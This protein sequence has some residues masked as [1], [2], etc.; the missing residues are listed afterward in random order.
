MKELMEGIRTESS[1]IS[2]KL[3][4]HTNK[5]LESENLLIDIKKKKLIYENWFKL[6]DLIGS[7]DGK[8]FRQFA[9]EYTLD[10]LLG[11]ANIHLEEFSTRYKL[12]RIPNTLSLQV[13]DKDM[14]DEIR[15][16]NTLSGGE[17]FLVSLAL[18]LG[19]ASL[20]SNKMKVESLFIDEGFGSLDP[21][22]LSIAMDALCKLK[23]QGRKVGVISH[24]AEMT[25]NITTQIRITKISNGRSKL[26]VI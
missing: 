19:L 14:G 13:L 8:K 12:S 20:S 6:N 21:A 23:D 2:N 26:E 3:L 25:E 15:S 1:A 4:L 17:S 7:A 9:Q 11:F 10:I 16:V 22:T 5:V 24:V 18:A